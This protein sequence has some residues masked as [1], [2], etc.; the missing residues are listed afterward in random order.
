MK[1]EGAQNATDPCFTFSPPDD[2]PYCTHILALQTVAVSANCG[3]NCAGA[4]LICSLHSSVKVGE[5]VIYYLFS[6]LCTSPETYYLQIMCKF[7]AL[8]H[9]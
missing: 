8:L 3:A 9:L 1:A 7:K 6:K 4:I 2:L 5:E